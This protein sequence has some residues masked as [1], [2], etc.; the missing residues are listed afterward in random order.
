MELVR[1][2]ST[3]LVKICLTSSIRDRPEPGCSLCH[4]LGLHHPGEDLP[5]QLHQR[6][7]RQ[8]VWVLHGL[9]H[10]GLYIWCKVPKS[11]HVD[12]VTLNNRDGLRSSSSSGASSPVPSHSDGQACPGSKVDVVVLTR[13]YLTLL[14]C[15]V[16]RSGR[17]K[18]GGGDWLEL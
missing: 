10:G 7:P 11:R 12:I 5:H 14:P 3:T 9:F 4:L 13:L 1:Q 15:K 2:I 17:G 18:R 16:H 6:P 8:P